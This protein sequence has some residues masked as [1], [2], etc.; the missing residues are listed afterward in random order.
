MKANATNV[1]VPQV[2]ASE[3]WG[4]VYARHP[5]SAN[6]ATGKVRRAGGIGTPRRSW[7]DLLLGAAVAVVLHIAFFASGRFVTRASPPEIVPILA[8][9][10]SDIVEIPLACAPDEPAPRAEDTEAQPAPSASAAFASINATIVPLD[11]LRGPATVMRFSCTRVVSAIGGNGVGFHLDG[12]A[13]CTV[14]RGTALPVFELGEL[15][16]PPVILAQPLP[17]YPPSLLRTG[18]SGEVLVC[19]V[20]GVDG[21]VRAA[22]SIQATHPEFIAPALQSVAR[23]KFR[24]GRKDGR[25][26]ATRVEVPIAFAVPARG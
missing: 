9:D 24:P 21:S 26:V 7:G 25:S 5:R 12:S 1:P 2:T 8:A 13:L 11:L 15:D 6:D 4:G 3:W 14:G 22:R 23:W 17:Q 18:A 16:Q 19:F 20:V 10:E